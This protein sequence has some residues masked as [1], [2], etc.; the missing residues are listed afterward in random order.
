VSSEQHRRIDQ[1]SVSHEATAARGLWI[2]CPPYPDRQQRCSLEA[3][4]NNKPGSTRASAS[5]VNWA[6]MP[7]PCW[8]R[9]GGGAFGFG[10]SLVAEW[11]VGEARSSN[12][13]TG[14]R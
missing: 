13:P 6:R 1:T 9:R 5:D 3:V 4:S 2:C 10:W 7:T 12:S 14:T 8:S 11:P